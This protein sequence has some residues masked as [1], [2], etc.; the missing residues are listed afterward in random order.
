MVFDAKLRIAM[1]GVMLAAPPA[2]A[3][4][5]TPAVPQ[6]DFVRAPVQME[7]AGI[8]CPMDNLGTAPAPQTESGYI[9]L[10]EGDQRVAVH[11]RLVPAQLGIS[12]GVR[13]RLAPGT[14]ADGYR[15]VVKHPAYGPS[16]MTMQ[17]WDPNI[18]TGWGVRSF[19]F[20]Y[21]RELQP[22]LW[23]MELYKEDTLMMRQS[24]QVVPPAQAPDAI[25]I[26]FGNT[27]IS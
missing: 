6:H 25:D 1:A 23:S 17:S 24:F 3:E 4:V 12:F 2:L 27:F 7:E 19:Q 8:Y 20:E 9:L 13:I 11:D 22:G 15:M 14:P 10:M 5:K 26:C 16:D 21:D 18:G